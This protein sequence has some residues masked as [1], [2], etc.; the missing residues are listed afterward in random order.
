MIE[1]Q[2]MMQNLANGYKHFVKFI[3]IY[4]NVVW[5]LFIKYSNIYIL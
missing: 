5:I 3:F 2:T 4:L 1:T